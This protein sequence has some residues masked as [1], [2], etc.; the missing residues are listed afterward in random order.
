VLPS[1]ATTNG[2]LIGISRPYRK[3]GLLHN[4]HKRHFGINGD[5]VLVVRGGS[6]IFNPSLTSE[7][8]R[9]SV[10]LIQ[11]LRPAKGMLN[12]APT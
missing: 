5:D 2:M 12:F 11:R 10:L 7:V 8:S 9:P 1:L 3:I 6:Q 4:K